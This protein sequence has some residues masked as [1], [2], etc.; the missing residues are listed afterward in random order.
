M[1]SVR[2]LFSAFPKL[3]CEGCLPKQT[4][5]LPSILKR[6]RGSLKSS[7]PLSLR[8]CFVILLTSNLEPLLL[9]ERKGGSSSVGRNFAIQS[10][11]ETSSP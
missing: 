1:T 6:G 4:I 5:W 11:R 9:E 10:T 2:P 7:P 3:F 8:S